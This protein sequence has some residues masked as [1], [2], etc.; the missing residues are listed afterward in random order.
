MAQG[1]RSGQHAHR[2]RRQIDTG[3]H[4]PTSAGGSAHRVAVL[5][6]LK[7]VRWWRP[8][9]VTS[10]PFGPR[11]R[12]FFGTCRAPRVSGTITRSVV[13][14]SRNTSTIIVMAFLGGD[15]DGRSSCSRAGVQVGTERCVWTAASLVRETRPVIVR[16]ACRLTPDVFLFAP[17]PIHVALVVDSCRFR[18]SASILKPYTH[19]RGCLQ[20]RL[21]G[22]KLISRDEAS[23]VFGGGG[24]CVLA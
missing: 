18:A 21:G 24:Q 13:P 5:G 10:K 4:I 20:T 1:F 15:F 16:V 2:T 12:S 6:I 9:H 23:P 3:N 7:C 17:Q 8:M 19:Y 22:Y 11:N 14:A